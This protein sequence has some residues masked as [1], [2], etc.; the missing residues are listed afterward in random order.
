MKHRAW[1]LPRRDRIERR[2]DRRP[3][4]RGSAPA[5]RMSKRISALVVCAVVAVAVANAALLSIG[6]E[7]PE[8]AVP[9]RSSDLGTPQ[10]PYYVAG[11]TEDSEEN[12]I[13]FCT[14]T[15]TNVNNGGV[16]V[17]ESSDVGSYMVNLVNMGEE[18]PYDDGDEILVEAVKDE[19]SGSDVGYVDLAGS[20][21]L[22]DVTLDTV[23]PEFSMVIVPVAGIL[24]VFAIV[25]SRRRR[26][27]EA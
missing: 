8:S 4:G 5:R 10:N 15:I 16:L 27:P 25:R 22:I 13:P 21:T 17:I 2:L 23:I 24:A 11:F 20:T 1:M 3:S 7:A 26:S 19:M 6:G 18:Y 12:P 9:G 14:V